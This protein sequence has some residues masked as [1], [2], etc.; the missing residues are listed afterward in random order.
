M[1]GKFLLVLS[2]FL[3]TF[4]YLKASND[5]KVISSSPT[6]LVIE[7]RP[8]YTDTSLV[9]SGTQQFRNV[10]VSGAS[11]KQ[12]DVP[13]MPL[14]PVRYFNVGVPSETGNTVQVIQ[15]EYKMLKGLVTPAKNN[16][17]EETVTPQAGTDYYNTKESDL[18]S[19]GSFGNS[20][21][22]QIQTIA[23][24]PVQFNANERTIKLYKRI[25]IRI[26][27]AQPRNT[28]YE[29]DDELLN[30]TVLNYDVAKKWGTINTQR[31]LSKPAAEDSPLAN[32]TW[33]RFACDEEGMYRI[34]RSE[35]SSLGIDAATVDPRTIKIYNNGGLVL[36]ENPEANYPG[37][38]VQNPIRVIGEEDGSFDANDYILFYGRG[39]NF[40][41]YNSTSKNIERRK[42]PY[43]KQNYYWITSGGSNGLRMAAAQST[44]ETNR[45]LQTYTLAHKLFEEDL[46]NLGS[47]GRQ[48]VGG[49][50]NT[51]SNNAS[52]VFTLNDM[53]PGMQR[54]YRV[55]FVNTSAS[56]KQLALDDNGT[57]ISSTFLTGAS[58]EYEIGR[59]II[60]S[61]FATGT[62]PDN[63]S[64]VQ[65]SY[66]ASATTD[67]GYLDYIELTFRREL[68]A[69]N[70]YQIFYSKDTTA[71]I[72]YT[73]SNYSNSNIEVYDV[74]DFTDV[75]RIEPLNI[76]GGQLTFQMFERQTEV[77]RYIGINP[78]GYKQIQNPVQMENSNL[79]G[80]ETGAKYVIITHKDF[81]SS[82]ERLANYRANESPYPI[83]T[84]IV[85]EDEIFNE[86]SN[87]MFDPTAIRNFLRK[88]YLNW[89]VKPEYIVLFGDGTYDFFNSEG[90]NNNY[91]PTYQ[92]HISF[93]EV[94]TYVTDDHYMRIIGND[95]FPD[96]SYGR[97]N[98]NSNELA[99]IYIDK[100]IDYEKNIEKGVWSNKITL[101]ADDGWTPSINDGS[102]HT[103][104][105]EALARNDIP[106]Y[107]NVNK[108]YL[109]SF[110][111]TF[112][113]LGRRKPQ[114]NEGIID[115]VNNGT[116]ILN[117]IGHGSP[118]VW[119]DERVFQKASSLPRLNNDKYF[120]LTAA[121][122]DFGKYDDPTVQSATE[123][124]LFMQGKGIIGAF[125]A[126]RPVYSNYNAAINS[127][128]YENLFF[129]D[130]GEEG[131]ITL[132]KAYYLTKQKIVDNENDMKFH[133]FGDP[134]LRLRVPELPVIIDEVN[135]NKLDIAVQISAL[136]S[137]KVEGTV[138]NA[139]S[140][141]NN[142]FTGEGILS[143]FDSERRVQLKD[144]SNYTI[145]QQGG[146]IFRGRVSIDNG[147]F[148]TSFTVPKD[149][150]YE[151][152]NGKIVAYIFD[153]NKDGIGFTDSIRVGGTDPDAVDDGK[154]PNI[155]IFFDNVNY[156]N[157][158]LVNSDFTLLVELNDDTGLNTT[159]TGVGHKIE[160]I[161][162]DDVDS[163]I[164]FT[165]FFV[166]DLDAGGKAGRITY[167]FSDIE[168]GEHKIKIKAW[169][170]FNNPTEEET[171]FSV[172]DSDE[173][174]VREIYNYPNPFGG[175]TTFTF[176]HNVNS[177]LNVK[178]KVYTIAGRLIKE[179]EEFSV[180]DR[181]VRIPWDGRDEDGS[182]IA[183]GTYLYK[184]IVE[185]SDGRFSESYLGKLAVIR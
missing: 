168:T 134:Y 58:G 138:R 151:N 60:R 94:D 145:D 28:L 103:S 44:N 128:F 127:N 154:G 35:L 148:A 50:F 77:S 13:G 65:L 98:L 71:Y 66:N 144:L 92:S 40:W 12:S 37:D 118:E 19:F 131:G 25:V 57:R 112:T 95:R 76:S 185:S 102:V 142:G 140:T 45:Y 68:K 23:V 78:N 6:Q 24:H 167:N 46:L 132:G 4:T 49:E 72:G 143:V 156:E 18:V 130:T 26:N 116:L 93:H 91:I 32:G 87:G 153:E 149:I 29:L 180:L 61:S 22:L 42:H 119:A 178:I 63:R 33:Y 170:V 162:D 181:F 74:T 114:V 54:E 39:V 48:Y 36:P 9:A 70:D 73:I 34:S 83:S 27:F 64:V 104:Q 43:S 85:Y 183:N 155:D 14:L 100:I 177:P 51:T 173:L 171:Y 5:V 41:E 7:Y 117:Y 137:V 52:Y 157:S 164:D 115:A 146:V 96:L 182:S 163:P 108:V 184:L 2:L 69:V 133:L 86:Y 99:N 81:T 176:Q 136:G 111:P 135:D 113:G 179:I 107:F 166:G 62:L 90:L 106:K 122:C 139:D 160:G 126:A 120:F 105:S 17:A 101:V 53:I 88:A 20:R 110:E 124:M 152:K 47:T 158:Y 150:S 123:E 161:L 11:F 21:G 30:G 75:K 141:M 31:G 172:V 1:K 169:D 125:T 56:S 10:Y 175:N 129:T 147:E 109:G 8:N 82:A 79:H 84:I 15:T 80:I 121:T 16:E 174:T 59:Q 89:G 165:D 67:K 97:I 159:G 55:S 38:M 3:C